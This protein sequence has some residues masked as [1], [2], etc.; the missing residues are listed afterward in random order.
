MR[1]RFLSSP[2]V[3]HRA[4]SNSSSVCSCPSSRRIGRPVTGDTGRGRR[5]QPRSKSGGAI[6]S[7][8]YDLLEARTICGGGG[9][10]P[11]SARSPRSWPK[12]M[13][14]VLR[15]AISA[16]VRPPWLSPPLWHA[17]RTA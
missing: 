12:R 17:S 1:S 11:A 2:L 6:D 5:G 16:Q 7:A 3:R 14:S 4:S 13:W 15:G 10:R 9:A 8:T